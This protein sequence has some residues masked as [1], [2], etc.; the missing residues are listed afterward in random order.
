MVFGMGI[1]PRPNCRSTNPQPPYATWAT[2]ARNIQDAVNVAAFGEVIVS[3]KVRDEVEAGGKASFTVVLTSQP[4]TDVVFSVVAS[5]A[6]EATVDKSTL[7][8]TSGNWNTAQTVTI[9]AVEVTPDYAHAKVFFSLLV[10]DPAGPP[11]FAEFLGRESATK[12]YC[13]RALTGA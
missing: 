9:Q 5:D 3:E 11:G 12:P 1:Q 6:T 8:F 10:G 2:A 13:R 7:T 4:L